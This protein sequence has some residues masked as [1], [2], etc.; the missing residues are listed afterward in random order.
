MF[1]V[2]TKYETS[3]TA[4]ENLHN[5]G[6]ITFIWAVSEPTILVGISESA[7]YGSNRDIVTGVIMT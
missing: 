4:D 5:T 3:V 2:A 6:F 1:V 7:C